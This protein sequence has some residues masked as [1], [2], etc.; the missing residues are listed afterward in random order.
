MIAKITKSAA[1]DDRLMIFAIRMIAKTTEK[2]S[3]GLAAS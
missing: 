3:H 2:C 1:K